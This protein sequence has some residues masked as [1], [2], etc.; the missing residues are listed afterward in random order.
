M[1][2]SADELTGVDLLQRVRRHL[3][4]VW[5]RSGLTQE[6][7]AERAGIR[8]GVLSKILDLDKPMSELRARVLLSV[9]ADGLRVSLPAFFAELSTRHDARSKGTVP[10]SMDGVAAASNA[11]SPTIPKVVLEQSD[12]EALES[13]AFALLRAVGNP[14]ADR[15]VSGAGVARRKGRK[16]R[17]H[18]G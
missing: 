4:L 17:T 15:Q 3:V 18:V 11:G 1:E 12:A 13:L 14:I 6:I 10:V 5:R 8:Q 16:A 9:I 7:V 2:N